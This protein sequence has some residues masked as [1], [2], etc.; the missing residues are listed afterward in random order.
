[1]LAAEFCEPQQ[2]WS[3]NSMESLCLIV[4]LTKTFKAKPFLLS[5][6]ESK[7]ARNPDDQYFVDLIYFTKVL[8]INTIIRAI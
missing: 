8:Q 2:S 4:S 1:M 5:V 6:Q 3:L 7:L